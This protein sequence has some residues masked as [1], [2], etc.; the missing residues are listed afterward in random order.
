MEPTLIRGG[1]FPTHDLGVRADEKVG[2]R[3]DRNRCI[4]LRHPA[5]PIR[6]VCRG[7]DVGRR[8]GHIKDLDAP[9]TYPVGGSRRICIPDTNLGQTHRV[10]G[11]A[12]TCH[13]IGDRFSGPFVERRVRVE[14]VDEYVGVQKDHGSRVIS[15]SFSHV[16]FGLSGA[17]RI[18]SI[19]AFLLI[20]ALRFGFSSRINRKRPSACCWMSKTSPGRPAGKTIR[21][22]VSTLNVLI[23]GI[24]HIV[25]LLS[26]DHIMSD[27]TA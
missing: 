26:R 24:S 7:T 6:A 9:A 3:H 25:I 19:H 15:R 18:A 10:D 2:E 14:G 17:L 27:L 1:E 16:S 22:L 11:G 20:F 4:G 8:G 12:V 13:S 5:L 21:F 23:V